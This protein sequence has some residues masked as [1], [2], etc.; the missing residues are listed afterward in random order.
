MNK[1]QGNYSTLRHQSTT[2]IPKKLSRDLQLVMQYG[3]AGELSKAS[4]ICQQILRK[5]PKNAAA[6]HFAGLIALQQKKLDKAL[7]YFNKAIAVNPNDANYYNHMAVAHCELNNYQEGVECYKKAVKLQPN[8]AEAHYNLAIALAKIENFTEA[9]TH[10]IKSIELNP[11]NP[12][13]YNNLGNVRQQQNKVNEAIE[14][15][16]RALAINPNYPEYLCNLGSALQKQEKFAESLLAYRQAISLKPDYQEAHHNAGVVSV[17]LN[18]PRDAVMH[19][20]QSLLT[21]PDFMPSLIA[22]ANVYLRL[23]D[24]DQAIAIYRNGLAKKPEDGQLLEGIVKAM[25]ASCQWD[26]LKD[27]TERLIT[28]SEKRIEKGEPCTPFNFLCLG[29]LADKQLKIAKNFAHY[30]FTKLGYLREK[31]GFHFDRAPKKKI[32][33]GYVSGDIRNHPT[34]HLMMNMFPYHDRDT[35]EIF[36]YSIGPRD[37]S[38][39]RERIPTLCDHFTDLFENT[40]EECAK[41]IYDDEID[42]LIDAMG[43]TQYSRTQIFELRPAP[44]QICFLAYPGTMGTNFID[45]LVSD[46]FVVP[47]AQTHCYSEKL[48]YMPN[49]YFVTDDQQKIAPE[50]PSRQECGLPENAF[51]FCCFNR[52][53]KI[54]SEVFDVWADI[55]NQIPNAVLW[56]YSDIPA[57]EKNL[58]EEIKKRGISSEKLIF[59]HQISKDKHLARQKLADL[60]LDCFTVNAHTT[61]IDALWAGVPVITCSGNSIISRASGSILNAIGLP[62]LIAKDKTHYKELAILYAQNRQVLD[63]IKN[64]LL[65]NKKTHPLF[66]TQQYVSNLEKGLKQVWQLYLEDRPP[67]HIII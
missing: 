49:T 67:E 12:M 27:W 62:E 58:L 55:L 59:A 61:A 35:F 15:Y 54:D 41:Q 21:N 48:F 40:F 51:V 42:I 11:N 10:Y 28:T 43:Y 6:L 1:H 8:F 52:T 64:K 4:A 3:Q 23:E 60:F 16:Q 13:S 7:T 66:N 17:E 38:I 18:K 56:L 22:L 29:L 44:I 63:S 34:S 50:I 31:L 33:I 9:E 57:A 53:Y 5:Y 36:L 25:K 37:N 2:M 26:E 47:P 45:Y 24:Y 30:N 32:R 65:N 19:F 46:Q 39:Y 14:S 20:N